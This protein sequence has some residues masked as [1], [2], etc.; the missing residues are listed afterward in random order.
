MEVIGGNML[1]ATDRPKVG[2]LII[3]NM[4]GE[5]KS[6]FITNLYFSGDGGNEA[7]NLLNIEVNDYG[8]LDPK[9]CIIGLRRERVLELTAL[10]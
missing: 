5:L 8:L 3:F 7:L 10:S 1:L 4:G 2:D 6:A 9:S